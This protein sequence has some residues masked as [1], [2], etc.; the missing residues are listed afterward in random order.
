MS[1][2]FPLSLYLDIKAWRLSAWHYFKRLFDVFLSLCYVPM[3][4]CRHDM[5]PLIEADYDDLAASF[6]SELDQFSVSIIKA[7]MVSA[8][9]AYTG[10][11]DVFHW[12]I[13][14]CSAVIWN[15][16][17][18]PFLPKI[19]FYFDFSTNMNIFVK[20][21]NQF[22]MKISLCQVDLSSSSTNGYQPP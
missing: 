18:F 7:F 13:Y 9:C 19:R 1:C 22:W 11:N 17:T 14:L 4:Y 20:K 16:S 12:V 15:I 3:L 10:R 5:G 6:R 2:I 8:I 21:C